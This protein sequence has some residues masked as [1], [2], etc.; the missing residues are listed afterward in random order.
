MVQW[1]VEHG[2]SSVSANIDA[3]AKIRETV[4]KTEKHIILE[5]AR[6]RNAE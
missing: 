1:L 5:A 3:I 2:I 6:N 4:A